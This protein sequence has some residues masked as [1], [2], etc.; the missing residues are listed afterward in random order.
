MVTV[1]EQHPRDVGHGQP[2]ETYR[3]AKGG[4]RAGQQRRGEEQ[5]SARTSDVQPHRHGILLAEQQQ[6]ERLDGDYGQQQSGDNRRDEYRKLV[7]G[8]VAECSHR[9]DDEHFQGF[10]VGDVLQYLDDRT[11]SRRE[12]HAENQNHH[13]VLDAVTDGG[14]DDQHES[15][16]E[17]CRSGDA[18]RRTDARKH[19]ERHTEARTRTDAEHVGSCKGIAEEGLHLK[20]ADRQRGSG[21]QSH[22]RLNEPDVQDDFRRCP[23]TVAARQGRP[24]IAE[25]HGDSPHRQIQQ[26]QEEG[27]GGQ[28]GK[29]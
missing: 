19:H 21:Q 3:T 7:K 2:D 12:H 28:C 14:D 4:H 15:R 25:R 5:Q 16:S 6:V 17:P 24:Y 22:D 11:D 20:S 29:Q 10:I 27:E 18:Y 9:P 23:R 1:A 8:H 13:D 26:E